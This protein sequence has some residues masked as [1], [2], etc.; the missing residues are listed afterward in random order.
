MTE[1]L[2]F[3]QKE[4]L[5]RIDE[6]QRQMAT[7]LG[8]LKTLLCDKVDDGSEYQT[9]KQRVNEL[10]DFKNRA[11]GYAAGAGAIASFVYQFIDSVVISKL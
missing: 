2:D 8:E 10:W 4:L 6:R 11:L 9:M 3:T 7:D 1:K 5:I